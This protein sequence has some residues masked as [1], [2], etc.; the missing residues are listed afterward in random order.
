VVL[1]TGAPVATDAV[2]VT[3]AGGA[4][5]STPPF[6][7]IAFAGTNTDTTTKKWH[8]KPPPDAVI[9]HGPYVLLRAWRDPHGDGRTYTISFT[10]TDSQ[11]GSCSGTATVEVPHDLG[12]HPKHKDKHYNSFGWH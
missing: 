4:A 2:P 11:G 3:V 10:V 12:H 8:K 1:A 5:G 6:G 9:L 7:L